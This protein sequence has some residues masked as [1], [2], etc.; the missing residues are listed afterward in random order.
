MEQRTQPSPVAHAMHSRTIRRSELARGVDI[1][2]EPLRVLN[3]GVSHTSVCGVRDYAL[4]LAKELTRSGQDVRTEWFERP[5]S[6]AE[7]RRWIRGVPWADEHGEIDVILWHYS[8]FAYSTRGVPS[9]SWPL[10]RALRRAG[11]PVV[12]VL[13]E[14]AYP[15]GRNGWRGA[16]WAASQR[17][18]LVPVV[19]TSSGLV[20]TVE[21][22]VEWLR[23]RCWLPRRAAVMTPVFSTL[24]ESLAPS[25]RGFGS[26]RIGMFGYPT[27][28]ASLIT[29]AMALFRTAGITAEL[30]LLG[31]P[32][33]NTAVG[34]TWRRAG[35]AACLGDSMRFTGVLEK[36]ALASEIGLCDILIFDDGDGDGPTSRKTTVAAGLASGRPVVAV[37]GPKTWSTLAQDGSVWLVAREPTALKSALL[38]LANDSSRREALGA[39]GRAFYQCHQAPAVI[40]P[41]VVELLRECSH[42][43]SK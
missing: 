21:E 12:T 27:S 40:V 2:V 18:A 13:H 16:L 6:V 38:Q 31:S 9:L 17:L 15:W 28:S 34:E 25:T 29:E 41:K 5:S 43:P 24:A 42:L 3:L 23:Q 37:D 4:L 32:G 11:L 8:V 33:P 22:R 14:Y 1:D 36:E 39:R 20:V 30:S 10:A 19:A 35:T 7:A 26:V